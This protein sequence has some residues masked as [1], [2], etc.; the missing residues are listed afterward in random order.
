MPSRSGSDSRA[1]AEHL[2]AVPVGQVQV[3]DEDFRLELLDRAARLARGADGA[4]LTTEVAD[5]EIQTLAGGDVVLDDED[6]QIDSWPDPGQRAAARP[7]LEETNAFPARARATS[8]ASEASS[9]FCDSLWAR[10]RCRLRPERGVARSWKKRRRVWGLRH[11]RRAPP[12]MAGT[13]S[14]IESSLDR[15]PMSEAQC[16][17]TAPPRP[18]RLT[19]RAPSGRGCGFTPSSAWSSWARWLYYTVNTVLGLYDATLQIARY[20][21]L[22]ELTTDA[23]AGLSEASESLERY[24]RARR[25]LRPVPPLR[26]PHRPENGARGDQSAS[27]DRGALSDL[28][29]AEAAAEVYGLASDKAIGLR[30]TAS[31]GRVLGGRATTR[32]LPRPGAARLPRRRSSRSSAADSPS[33]SSASRTNAT[34]PRPP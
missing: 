22:R 17:R 10:S 15:H 21:D 11:G 27:P 12:G 5:R 26:G 30:A 20:T 4:R 14:C 19:A 32:R 18:R 7:L 33:R 24:V 8:S 9:P 34:P 29:S 31:P 28:R 23:T 16:Q 13:L 3:H 2:D 6:L 1:S 25:G